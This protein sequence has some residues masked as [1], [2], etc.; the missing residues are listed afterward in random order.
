M[1][2]EKNTSKRNFKHVLLLPSR[3]CIVVEFIILRSEIIFYTQFAD[4]FLIYYIKL[5]LPNSSNSYYSYT[6]SYGNKII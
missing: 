6:I 5:C 2:E 1:E 4:R 3:M